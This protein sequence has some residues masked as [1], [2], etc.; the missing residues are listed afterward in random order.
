VNVAAWSTIP[1]SAY[2]MCLLKSVPP[3]Q[4]GSSGTHKSMVLPAYSGPTVTGGWLMT[5]MN[6]SL[7]FPNRATAATWSATSGGIGLGTSEAVTP[8]GT[9]F[10]VTKPITAA[11]WEYP[12]STIAVRGQLATVDRT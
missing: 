1:V 11:P 10:A 4:I 12:P 9:A 3:E 7:G 2:S 6:R 5:R 8:S